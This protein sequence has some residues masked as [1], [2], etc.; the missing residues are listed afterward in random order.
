MEEAQGETGKEGGPPNKVFTRVTSKVGAATKAM[1]NARDQM[2]E[3]LPKFKKGEKTE[4]MEEAQGET[5]KAGGPPN[6]VF[7]RVTSKVGAATKAMGNAGEPVEMA[8][9]MAKAL[10]LEA[11]AGL[12]ATTKVAKVVEL[13]TGATTPAKTKP[14][15]ARLDK[16]EEVAKTKP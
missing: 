14:I 2:E 11:M 1:A 6:K 16:G 5:G 8:A 13:A 9:K 15:K 4:V 10:E 12:K 7:T 3:A